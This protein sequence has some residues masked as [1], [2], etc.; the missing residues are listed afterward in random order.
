[1]CTDIIQMLKACHTRNSIINKK[2]Y[3]E[4][5]KSFSTYSSSQLQKLWKVYLR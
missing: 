5:K 3:E 1:M 2:Y 4:G